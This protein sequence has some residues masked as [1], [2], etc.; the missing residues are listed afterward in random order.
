MSGG[1]VDSDRRS[2]LP[3]NW[4]T[5]LR[6]FVLQRDEYRCRWREGSRVCGHHANQV[7]HITPGDDHRPENLQALCQHHHAVKS[8]R[9]GNAARWRETA[10]RPPER[11]PGLIRP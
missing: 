8:S 11:H 2:E 7:D 3:D 10:R 5:E 1:W 6:P 9:E 4:Y